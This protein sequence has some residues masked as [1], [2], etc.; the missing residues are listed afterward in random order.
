[1]FE[2]V[3]TNQCKSFSV[4]YDFINVLICDLYKTS[5][6]KLKVPP[7]KMFF[8]ILKSL[9]FANF[10]VS[11]STMDHLPKERT[12]SGIE[13]QSINTLSETIKHFSGTYIFPSKVN[14]T[15]INFSS[16]SHIKTAVLRF[17]KSLTKITPIPPG[18]ITPKST[19]VGSLFFRSK[20]IISSIF[21]FSR[22]F[23]NIN[24]IISDLKNP[25]T[26]FVKNSFSLLQTSKA[27]K[28]DTQKKVV[29][30]NKSDVKKL[31]FIY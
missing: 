9:Q 21:S 1:M 27:L 10:A 8:A 17:L 15:S 3:H 6:G 13:K 16:I 24:P 11:K 26:S 31:C 29:Y 14:Q 22:T 30:F 2:R 7:G 18:V 28:I 23:A 5:R 12:L 20:N 19:T 4:Y 25:Y